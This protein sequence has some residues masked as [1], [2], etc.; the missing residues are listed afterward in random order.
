MF[1]SNVASYLEKI[2]LHLARCWVPSLDTT[3]KRNHCDLFSPIV[4]M[5]L[6]STAWRR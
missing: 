5:T 2:V 3:E 4:Y 6:M 1:F